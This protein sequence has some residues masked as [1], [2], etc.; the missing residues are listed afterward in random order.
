MSLG[1]DAGSAKG[2]ASAA[3]A[4]AQAKPSAPPTQPCKACNSKCAQLYEKHKKQLED[5]KTK[6]TKAQQ[7][8]VDK[9]KANYQAHKAEYQSVADQTGVPPE[10]VA[11]IHW[12]ESSGNFGT[13]LHQGDPLGKPPV[14]VPTDIPT[15]QKGE[16]DKAAANALNNKGKKECQDALGM[17]KDT[18]D[19]AAMAAYAERYNG[20]GYNNK[21]VASPYVYSGS[22]QYSAGKYVKD[23]V[24]S[25]TAVDQQVGVIPLVDSISGDGP[26]LDSR[27][28]PTPDSPLY[29]PAKLA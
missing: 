5:E 22:N 20:L 25:P 19:R 4:K 8:D 10:L 2:K 21:G 15:F 14:H 3:A 18:K 26:F 1:P 23:G 17:N 29:N 24:Y 13:Y 7:A 16:W 9:F 27:Y 12:R 6:L 11:A 28:I